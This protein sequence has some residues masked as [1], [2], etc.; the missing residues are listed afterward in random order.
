MEMYVQFLML[1]LTLLGNDN[2]I[3]VEF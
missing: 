1:I 3:D 2:E